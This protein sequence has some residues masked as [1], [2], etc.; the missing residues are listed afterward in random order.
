MQAPLHGR[1][2]PASVAGA[3]AK[4]EIAAEEHCG[5]GGPE[6]MC[7]AGALAALPRLLQAGLAQ[8]WGDGSG[9]DCGEPATFATAASGTTDDARAASLKPRL[10]GY[11]MNAGRPRGYQ[12]A[13]SAADHGGDGD[14]E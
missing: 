11:G 6:A 13:G 1:I 14:G 7:A 3:A 2:T 9:T 12:G 5:S 10:A 4:G 8:R